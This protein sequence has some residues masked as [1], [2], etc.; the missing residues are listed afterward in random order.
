MNRLLNLVE[1]F[2]GLMVFIMP[3]T[4]IPDRY[5]LPILGNNLPKIF[6]LFT[7]IF[8]CLYCWYNHNFKF[9]WKSYFT[10]FFYG[11]YFV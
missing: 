6:L 1:F 10:I 9:Y 3:F 8:Y 7:L 5:Q 11:P 2:L 4:L